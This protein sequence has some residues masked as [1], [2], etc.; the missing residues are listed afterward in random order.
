MQERMLGT[1]KG[2]AWRTVGGFFGFRVGGF[3]RLLA[4]GPCYSWDGHIH[5][6]HLE[7]TREYEDGGGGLS[8]TGGRGGGGEV[9]EVQP[10]WGCR[11]SQYARSR[12]QKGPL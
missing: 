6:G 2:K 9:Q 3:W 12:V 5:I 7:E 8:T 1:C 10:F 4:Q 11:P